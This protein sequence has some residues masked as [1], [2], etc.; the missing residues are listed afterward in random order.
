[1][2]ITGNGKLLGRPPHTKTALPEPGD[3]QHTWTRERLEGMNARFTE[4]LE[5]AFRWGRESRASA[6]AQVQLPATCTPRLSVPLCPDIWAA[7]LRTSA[8]SVA[9]HERRGATPRGYPAARPPGRE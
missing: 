5:W 3:E 7:L 9:D 1:M 2:A 4:R 6:A 8:P